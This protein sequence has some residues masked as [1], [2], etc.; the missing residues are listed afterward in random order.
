MDPKDNPFLVPH[1]PVNSVSQRPKP[2]SFKRPEATR[3]SAHTTTAAGSS[4]L[5][6]RSRAPL[7]SKFTQSFH[8]SENICLQPQAQSSTQYFRA[9][10]RLQEVSQPLGDHGTRL[11]LPS[12][13]P[14]HTK[15]ERDDL[16]PF[17]ASKVAH[18][19][20]SDAS[21]PPSSPAGVQARAHSS[22]SAQHT[23]PSLYS[24][25]E[26]SS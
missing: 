24:P 23:Q 15:S 3:N 20:T 18:I 14:I 9:L 6:I 16:D 5:P 12:A 19:S 11:N 21:N 22:G 26:T 7:D 1:Q 17:Y 4:N 8:L 25:R 2:F 10:P 13:P